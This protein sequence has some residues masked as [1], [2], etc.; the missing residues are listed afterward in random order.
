MDFILQPILPKQYDMN[1]KDR[2][3]AGRYRLK[4]QLAA[5]SF[6]DLPQFTDAQKFA[7]F[8]YKIDA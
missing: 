5:N 2:L 8:I 7:F 1:K 4:S 6:S 3:M